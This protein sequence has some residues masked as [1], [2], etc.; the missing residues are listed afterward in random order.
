MKVSHNS[1]VL[2]QEQ[3]LFYTG[4]KKTPPK[5]KPIPVREPLRLLCSTNHRPHQ[6]QKDMK[7]W[8]FGAK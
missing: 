1:K 6:L 3:K 7:N 2:R 5:T 8:P 4:H